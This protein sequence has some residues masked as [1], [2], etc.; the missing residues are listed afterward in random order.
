[1]QNFNWI[2]YFRWFFLWFCFLVV[3]SVRIFDLIVFSFVNFLFI[4]SWM[5]PTNEMASNDKRITINH[6]IIE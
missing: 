2:N 1:M 5:L 6:F 3:H 4:F